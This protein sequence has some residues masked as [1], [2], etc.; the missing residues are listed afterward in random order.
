MDANG[1]I[2]MALCSLA[3][4]LLL[5]T[6]KLCDNGKLLNLYLKNTVKSKEENTS[7]GKLASQSARKLQTESG[8]DSHDQPS[9]TNESD[10]RARRVLY[11][12]KYVLLGLSEW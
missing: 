7:V 4:K 12:G 5:I 11:I 8:K 1:A 9:P 10:S 6:Y 2:L 3:C